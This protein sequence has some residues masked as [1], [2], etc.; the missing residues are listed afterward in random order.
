[1]S[2]LTRWAN[3]A[4]FSNVPLDYKKELDGIMSKSKTECET[5]VFDFD[6]TLISKDTAMEFTKWLTLK[7]LPR[8]TLMLAVIPIM[9]LLIRFSGTQKFGYNM[10]CYISMAFQKKS[11]F[12]LRS[13]FIK[14][15]FSNVGAIVYQQGLAELVDHQKKGRKVVILS[16]CPM[17]L[18]HGLIKHIGIKDT[19][20]IGSK[21]KLV[22]G[23]MVIDKHCYQSRKLAMAKQAGLSFD[24]WFMGY[25]DS[26][27][28]IPFLN[29]CHHKVLVNASAKN[30]VGFKKKLSQPIHHR[31]W[32]E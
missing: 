28:D 9:L 18:L 15:L 6:G 23:A 16:G 24:G 27:A 10:A 4:F 8:T 12:T 25:S 19:Q 1:M 30:T 13:E 11:L 20:V 32:V 29:L 31:E 3:R 22:N 21:F 7:S 14:H 2:H 5:V 17:W 26:Q